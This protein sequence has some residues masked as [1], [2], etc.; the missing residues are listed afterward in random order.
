MGFVKDLFTGK[1]DRSKVYLGGRHNIGISKLF[2]TFPKNIQILDFNLSV[3]NAEKLQVSYT[4]FYKNKV[5]KNIEAK[6]C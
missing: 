1:V 6:N 3:F 5:Y 4:L 2:K